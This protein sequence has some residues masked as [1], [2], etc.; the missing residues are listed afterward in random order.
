MG[1]EIVPRWYPSPLG[2]AI[3]VL[4]CIFFAIRNEMYDNN[5]KV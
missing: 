4:P 2:P 1:P 3:T 5:E